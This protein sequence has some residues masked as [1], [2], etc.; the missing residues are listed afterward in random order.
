[1][2]PRIE[3]FTSTIYITLHELNA[4]ELPRTKTRIKF[5]IVDAK[6]RKFKQLV[7]IQGQS[8]K[9]VTLPSA[10]DILCPT[11]SA[12]PEMKRHFLVFSKARIALSSSGPDLQTRRDQMVKLGK[13][14]FH[15]PLPKEDNQP[16][17]DQAETAIHTIRH[18]KSSTENRP[19]KLQATE[20][21]KLRLS[22]LVYKNVNTQKGWHSFH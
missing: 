13:T 20:S 14:N 21:T 5:P 11:N 2:L 8:A 12:W 10:T 16:R 7:K 9:I 19:K 1:M 17:K 3:V 15:P 4:L 18:T 22:R 6:V